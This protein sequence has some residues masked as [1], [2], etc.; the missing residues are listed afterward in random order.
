MRYIT[1]DTDTRLVVIVIDTV[2]Y[3]CDKAYTV[4]MHNAL[5][6]KYVVCYLH[7]IK[8]CYLQIRVLRVLR[9]KGI[10]SIKGIIV[11]RQI[12][13]CY[14]HQI[15]TTVYGKRSFRHEKDESEIQL[16]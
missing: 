15:K 7:Q 9:G 13:T 3:Y 14:R 1:F 5:Y 4:L 16:W 10:R 6:C 12:K 8:I 11:I 2:K